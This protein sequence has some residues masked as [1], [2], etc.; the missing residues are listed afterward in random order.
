MSANSD[1]SRHSAPDYGSA[2]Y[3]NTRYKADSEPF[4][5]YQPWENVKSFALPLLTERKCALNIGCGTSRMT[6]LLLEDGFEEVVGFDIS[7]VVIEKSKKA[8]AK[9][10]RIKWICGDVLSMTAIES[11][12]FDVVLD[13]GTLDSLICGGC[14]Q[15]KVGQMMSEVSRVLKPGGVFMDISYGL[16]DA[17]EHYFFGEK[18]NWKVLPCHQ[19][20][21]DDGQRV[22][23]CYLAVK[24]RK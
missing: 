24:N 14:S 8:Y 15:K 9:E 7:S 4:D 2:D 13:K 11:D 12:K 10:R 16:P 1:L 20:T 6:S 19:V 3:W 22:H 17:R 18:L 5:W 23:Y 21:K